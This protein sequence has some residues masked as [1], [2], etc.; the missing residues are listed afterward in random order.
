MTLPRDP[1]ES[2][3]VDLNWL[4]AS[5]HSSLILIASASAVA[6]LRKDRS[7]LSQARKLASK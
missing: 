6:I 4:M 5:I 1:G 2:V 7:S 3:M